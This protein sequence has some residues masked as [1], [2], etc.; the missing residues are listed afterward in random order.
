[1]EFFLRLIFPKGSFVVTKQGNESR[2]LQAACI[3][4]SKLEFEVSRPRKIPFDVDFNINLHSLWFHYLS[5][6]LLTFHRLSSFFYPHCSFSRKNLRKNSNFLIVE[7]ST[8][9]DGC[10]FLSF[11]ISGITRSRHGHVA[12][13]MCVF[14][15]TL[16][17]EMLTTTWNDEWWL[18]WTLVW[19]FIFWCSSEMKNKKSNTTHFHV[20]S[21]I[22]HIVL[23]K[24]DGILEKWWNESNNKRKSM[25]RRIVEWCCRHSG[26]YVFRCLFLVS[27]RSNSA[28]H[29]AHSTAVWKCKRWPNYIYLPAKWKFCRKSNTAFSTARHTQI[30]SFFSSRV[31]LHANKSQLMFSRAFMPTSVH[32][33]PSTIGP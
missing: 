33:S 20:P 8:D 30:L 25:M 19:V 17:L 13:R 24:L 1:M 32:N 7:L 23:F 18:N 12:W 27:H 22:V 21:D 28:I 4:S 31:W 26:P 11:V 5:F 10:L 2:S 3:G 14:G 6:C 9:T 29:S 15:W 16:K